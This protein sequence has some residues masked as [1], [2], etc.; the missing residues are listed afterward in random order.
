MIPA[1]ES[2]FGRPIISEFI[3]ICDSRQIKVPDTFFRWDACIRIF[4]FS[5]A[6]RDVLASE[7]ALRDVDHK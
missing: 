3:R 4:L 5:L 2:R 1:R 7:I 6:R